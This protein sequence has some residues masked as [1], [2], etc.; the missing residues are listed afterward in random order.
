VRL[1]S[2]TP[3]L[4]I[5]SWVE[6]SLAAFT[7]LERHERVCLPL[8]YYAPLPMHNSSLQARRQNE[9]RRTVC[10][11]EIAPILMYCDYGNA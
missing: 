9:F 1:S 2:V 8:S 3:V 11:S 6:H 4:P 10:E 7:G 5:Q